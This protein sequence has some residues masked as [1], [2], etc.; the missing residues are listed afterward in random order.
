M[1]RK[2]LISSRNI[3]R[4]LGLMVWA[5]GLAQI[6]AAIFPAEA[7]FLARVEPW[8]P[9]HIHF[10]SRALL[11]VTGLSLFGLGRGI[12]RRKRAAW[13]LT[14]TALTISPLL[15]LG[16]DFGWPRALASAV[17]LGLLLAAR[18]HFR[19]RSD[20]GSL[21]WAVWIAISSALVIGVFGWAVLDRF[22]NEFEGETSTAGLVQ[23]VAELVLLQ[24]TD[25]IEPR[26]HEAQVAM[27]A[28]SLAGATAGL[29]TLV[30]A[31]NPVLR[32]PRPS[33]HDIE[34]VRAIMQA[35]GSDP[36]VEF[37][38]AE[39]K[40][41]FF[42]RSGHSVVAFALWR[43][44]ALTL[45]DPIGPAG[46]QTRAIQEFV[47][48][49]AEQDWEPVFYQTGPEWLDAYREAGFTVFK[50]GENA[51]LPLREFALKGSRFQDLRTA[52]SRAAREGISL[53]WIPAG[54]APDPA[55]IAELQAVSDGWLAAK[56]GRE[57]A[58]DM[59]RFSEQEILA[60]GAVVAMR[61]DGRV[62]AFA[63]WL[64]YLDGRGR[65]LDL[66]RSRPG[67]PGVMD[68]VIV[69][70]LLAFQAQG[71]SEAS[72]ANAPLA[73]SAVPSASDS[74]HDRAVRYL[75]ERFTHIYGY[76]K[77]FEFK[78]KYHPEW[79]GRYLAYRH[80]PELPLIACAMVAVHLP[81]GLI[82]FVRS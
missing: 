26:T 9:F 64:P 24:S 47:T 8:T 39:D 1:T 62:E 76:K 38:L 31:L 35:H 10:G 30:F 43:H 65:C 78:K 48:F 45:A 61:A 40:R 32:P 68:F 73:N 74:R 29:L 37:A 28:I 13:W 80:A 4:A 25:T 16:M 6:A 34:R 44:F 14:V 53:R 59:G 23:T 5:M 57:M 51:R 12:W 58:F 27:F 72:L 20:A 50:I 66:M 17:P 41:F 3:S 21:R 15:H 2:T 63:T 22:R 82:K 71:L 67:V 36:L 46:E 70:S 69:E 33:N 19:A 55:L 56:K 79:C 75:Y 18:K 77:L 7:R 52:R 81:D 49:C 42:T 60:R 54:T 11:L